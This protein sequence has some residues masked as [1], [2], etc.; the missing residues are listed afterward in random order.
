MF[1]GLSDTLGILVD[2]AAAAQAGAAPGGYTPA[3]LA[4]LQQDLESATRSQP[5]TLVASRLCLDQLAT[6]A[7]ELAA[8]VD[9]LDADPES[10]LRWWADAFAGQC[11]AALDELTLLAPWTELLVLSE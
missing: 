8:G 6:S 3:Q 2:A 5:T 9:A 11:R 7:A 10:Q 4:Q 1:E